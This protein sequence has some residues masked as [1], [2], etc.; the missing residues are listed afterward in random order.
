MTSRVDLL[1][2]ALSSGSAWDR[3]AALDFL[4]LFPEDAPKLLDLLVDLSLS[5]GWALP[6]REA[7]RA[8][9]KE[10]DSSKFARVALECLSGGE[11]EDYL[12]LADVLAEVEAWEAL[13]AVIGKAAESS[14]PEIRKVFRSFKES[15]GACCLDW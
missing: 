4:H 7:I 14:D 15:H 6:A 3:S 13:S 9:R 1:A 11:V 10:I 12:S 5:T 8:A 2:K